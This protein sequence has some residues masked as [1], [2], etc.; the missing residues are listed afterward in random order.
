M[1]E[2]ERYA[3]FNVLAGVI[4]AEFYYFSNRLQ[5]APIQLE[6]GHYGLSNAALDTPWPKVE[7]GK[8]HLRT[9]LESASTQDVTP[10]GLANDLFHILANDE[11]AEDVALPSTGISLDWERRL[12]SMFIH[13]E[14]YRTRCSTVVLMDNNKSVY[15][16]ER[17]FSSNGVF[18]EQHFTF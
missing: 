16:W 5:Q 14:D 4:G 3:G 11:Q 2:Q 17:S 7:R 8:Q 13:G 10:A 18:S 15:C 1:A 9:L 6:A 12:S